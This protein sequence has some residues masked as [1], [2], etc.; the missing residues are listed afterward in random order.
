MAVK[1]SIIVPVYNRERY[2][3]RCVESLLA[4]TLKEIQIILVDDGSTD[5]S[6][7]VCRGY[8]ER[9]SRVCVVHKQ[10]EGLGLTRNCGME[11]ADG[12]FLGFVDSDDY[13][14]EDMYQNLY[15]TAVRERADLVISGIRYDGGRTVAKDTIEV[16][17][18]FGKLE[19]FTSSQDKKRLLLGILGALPGE[20][21]DSRY[22]FSVCKNLF[23]T[24]L[25]KENGL[26]FESERLYISEDL[27]FHVDYIRCM[28]DAVGVPEAYYYY[29]RNPVSL[30]KSYQE[31]RF[32]R[33]VVLLEECSRRCRDLVSEQEFW[34]YAGRQLQANA[35]TA[36][37]QEMAHAE[38]AK[39]PARVLNRKILAIC[40]DERLMGE[41]RR[42]PYWK[43]PVKQAVFASAMRHRWIGLLKVLIVLRSRQ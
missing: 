9:D 26:R 5:G 27:L 29:Y 7:A 1:V 13:V 15:E 25:I 35:R 16:E 2:I 39:L 8:A 32:A 37:F 4:Q 19:R 41:L 43:L 36:I 10:N 6:L 28:K 20:K 42:Y 30:T 22:N 11:L 23:R 18:Y 33:S 31:N 12:E 3:A 38:E 21:N 40:R 17:Q 14:S 24:S 34:L